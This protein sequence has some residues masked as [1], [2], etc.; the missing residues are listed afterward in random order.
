MRGRYDG[1][2]FLM[3]LCTLLVISLLILTNMQHVLLYSKALN[4][5]E[6]QHQNFY[7]MEDILMWLTEIQTQHIDKDCFIS[8]KGANKVIGQLVRD[9]GCLVDGDT[10]RY[11][12]LIEDLGDFPCMVVE[13]KGKLLSTHHFRITLLQRSDEH[14]PAS[15]VLQIRDIKAIAS[16]SCQG[17][18]HRVSAGIS[19][20]RY[21]PDV[22]WE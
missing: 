16:A 2:I 6:Y 9:D 3:T 21:I 19:S 18:A 22:E 14:N 20:W 13:K 4:R 17:E 10:L 15:S 12:Y 1:F 8:E 11:R 5:Q 7:Q